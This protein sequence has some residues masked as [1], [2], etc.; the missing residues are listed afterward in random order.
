ML[1]KLASVALGIAGVEFGG[2]T[3][4]PRLHGVFECEKHAGHAMYDVR[5]MYRI[6]DNRKGLLSR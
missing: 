6:C 1:V 4:H 2:L 5:I 3:V